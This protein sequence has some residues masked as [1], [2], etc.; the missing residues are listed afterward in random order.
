[1]KNVSIHL[2]VGI[3][4]GYGIPETE[5]GMKRGKKRKVHFPLGEFIRANSKKSR[6]RFNFFAAEFFADQSHFQDLFFASREQIRL[7]QNGL[8]AP[9]F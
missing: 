2:R 4:H 5:K 1:L 7:V 9:S 8:K 6:Y 3:K